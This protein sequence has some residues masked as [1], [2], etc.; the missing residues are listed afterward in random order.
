MNILALDSSG[1]YAS[2]ALLQNGKITGDMALCNGLVHSR[3]LL[4]MAEQ[5]LHMTGVSIREID[6]FAVTVGPGSFTGVRIGVCTVKGLAQKDNKP[7]VPVHTLEALA[8]NI[9]A[10]C[11]VVC[12]LLDARREQ[13]YTAVYDGVQKEILLPQAMGI[14]ELAEYLQTLKQDVVFCGD[15]TSVHED[16]LKNTLGEKAHFA[17]AHLNYIRAAAVAKIGEQAMAQQKGISC[18]ELDALYLRKP[19]A[20]RKYERKSA[21]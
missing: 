15:G 14:G 21:L 16:F 18:F 13:V 11:K 20:E 8:Y 4:P 7:C 3:S 5:V 2:A 10:D 19:Q 1:P 9:T 6:A 17:P 12:P